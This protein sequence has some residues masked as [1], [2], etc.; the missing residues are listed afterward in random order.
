[1]N[2]VVMILCVVIGFPAFFV[3]L[4]APQ[5]QGWFLLVGTV[6][7]ADYS[8]WNYDGARQYFIGDT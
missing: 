1:M 4:Q 7:A 5:D 8:G 3:F 2:I 6:A